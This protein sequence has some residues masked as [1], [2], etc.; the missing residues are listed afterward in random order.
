MTSLVRRYLA[1]ER[2]PNSIQLRSAG[3]KAKKD[4]DKSSIKRIILFL[5]IVS[6]HLSVSRSPI[7]SSVDVPSPPSS[8][9]E[10][11]TNFH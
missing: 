6:I 1:V 4:S 11:Q 2:F 3:T 8:S 7:S 9:L 5:R 10:C